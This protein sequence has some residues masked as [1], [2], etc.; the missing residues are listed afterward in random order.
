MAVKTYTVSLPDGRQVDVEG[1]E[2][3]S[4]EQLLSFVKKQYEAGVFGEKQE[5]PESSS[6]DPYGLLGNPL[7]T[8][9]VLDA[10]RTIGTGAI[11]D[12]AGKVTDIASTPFTSIERGNELGNMV[13]G[14]I[15]QTP[16]SSKGQQYLSN[17]GEFFQP[18]G[19]AFKG[20]GE[21][22]KGTI[23]SVTGSE[24]AGEMTVDVA[25]LIPDLLGIGIGVK[26][27]RPIRIK[28]PDG[29]PTAEFRTLLEKRGIEYEALKPE[30]AAALPEVFYGGKGSLG[31]QV[32]R[33]DIETGGRQN[34]LA[35]EQPVG[36]G[37]MMPDPL[38]LNAVKAGWDE[39]FVAAV[40][41]ATPETK[42]SML[43]MIQRYRQWQAKKTF[44]RDVGR[45]SDIAG[46]AVVERISF[47]R[48]TINKANAQKNRIAKNKF[49]GLEVDI[50]PIEKV[51]LEQLDML[52]VRLP[53]NAAGDVFPDF[54]GSVIQA[55]RSAQRVIRD[56]LKLM[57][58][59]RL[60]AAGLHRLKLQFDN[61]IDYS[62][63]A[64]K[65]TPSGEKLVKKVRSEINQ[66]LRNL[67]PDYAQANDIV[68]E[69]LGV[70]DNFNKSTGR[71]VE[72]FADS[73]SK[74]I[75]QEMR[76]LFSNYG[77]RVPLE[78]AIKG[79]EETARKFATGGTGK[80]I[81]KYQEG[82]PAQGTPLPVFGT[83]A[84]ELALFASQ[85]DKR[86]KPV[87]ETSFLGEGIQFGRGAAA[88]LAVGNKVGLGARIL[89]KLKKQQG[90]G[91]DALAMQALEE[92]AKRNP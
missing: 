49:P 9:G 35:K 90:I 66:T 71:T 53:R 39:G 85:L 13:R 37:G 51:A 2:N 12:I 70:F 58:T 33:R 31:T 22:T 84:Y 91:D 63:T 1:P 11:G 79:L 80:Q 64:G 78:D 75:G 65:L 88:D 82:T 74:T 73:A 10:A 34:I 29:T 76:K 36:Q 21:A 16:Y 77:T 23:A 20:V 28:N 38:G 45:P 26:L 24:L 48:D 40:K 83:D 25:S 59:S 27:A 81:I 50:T 8:L 7:S 56:A 55:D 32:A 4:Q 5:Q 14:A 87:A 6:Q 41:T 42:S 68:S 3:A 61:L 17:V 30:V 86:F 52:E 15:T 72:I 62:R 69:G 47:I 89:E 92:L 19:E 18:V 43:K 60:D 67:D 54:N 46:D 57:Q 44:A